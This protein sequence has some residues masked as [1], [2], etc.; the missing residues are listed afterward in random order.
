MLHRIVTLNLC[1]THPVAGMSWNF[2]LLLIFSLTLP[3][4]A[5]ADR[6]SEMN[7][8][9]RC[10]YIA[11]LQVAGYC[12]FS[13]GCPRDQVKIHWHDDETQY[14]IDFVSEIFDQTCFWLINAGVAE[15]TLSAQAFGDLVYTSCISGRAL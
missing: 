1:T 4:T 10:T 15:S 3:A 6:I 8:A 13:Q 12:Y 11:K 2:F 14:E 7:P 5:L 9:E